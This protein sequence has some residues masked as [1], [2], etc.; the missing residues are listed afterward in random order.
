QGLNEIVATLSDFMHHR[1]PIIAYNGVYDFTV[2]TAE[3]ARRDAN[4]FP[5]V[6][7]VDP[8]VLDK[9]AD[10]YRKGKRTLEAA[11]QHYGGL[12]DNAH[13][14]QADSIAAVEVWQAMVA[15]FPGK[16]DVSLEELFDHQIRWKSDQSASF[17]QYLRRKNPEATVS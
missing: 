4:E 8:Y 2:L 3:L 16:V 5:V 14:S 10:T 9:Y 6:G 11:C 1:V 12:L 13:T 17:E 15:K 7:V